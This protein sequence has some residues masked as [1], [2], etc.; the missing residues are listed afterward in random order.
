MMRA[1]LLIL[2][3]VIM[4]GLCSCGSDVP[5]VSLD[6]AVWNT[7]YS[8]KYRGD[9]TLADS[10]RSVFKQV[11][12]SLSPFNPKSVISRVNNNESMSVDSHVE[13]VFALSQEINTVSGGAFDP[14]LSP[15]INLWGFGYTE[16]SDTEPSDSVIA[17][18]LEMVGIDSCR[19]EKGIVC[20]KSPCT[21]FN[22]SAVAKGYGCDEIAR[23]FRRN[24]IEDFMIE[25]GGE[26]ALSGLN[27]R[28][29][30]WRVMVDAPI[31]AIS[32]HTGLVTVELTDC[33][34]ATSGN[35]RNFRDTESGRVGHTISS[36]TGRPVVTNTLS[37]TVIAEDC[38][39][40]DALATACMAMQADSA[41]AM[42]E[43]Y[44]ATE[45]MLITGNSDSLSVTVTS[46][47]PL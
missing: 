38:A 45:C 14:T 5:F 8:I 32:G 19:I 36:L 23:M 20:K 13:A 43:R 29:L 12:M 31:E 15:L 22:F 27:D 24:G 17:V 18:T 37:A 40:A 44:P 10:V 21:T 34:I 26:I 39:T 28:G 2:S 7:E 16:Y 42:V 30:P 47:F 11:E 3:G 41:L 25:I 33:G 6:G 35:Y 46:G 9:E 1:G 4:S